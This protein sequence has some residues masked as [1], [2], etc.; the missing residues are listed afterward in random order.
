MTRTHADHPVACEN[1]QTPLQGD[2][3]YRCGQS[4]HNPLRHTGHALEEVFESF[5]HLDGR[6]FRTLRDLLSPGRAA[7][8][9]L[10]G[11]R[12]RYIPPLRMFV[13]LSLLTF[14][15]GKL[16]V[17]A[18]ST[19]P[20]NAQ[21]TFG[22]MQ[23]IEQV[24]RERDRLLAELDK[25]REDARSGTA[26]PGVDPA[27]IAAQVRIRGEANNRITELRKARGGEA[28]AGSAESHATDPVA[29]RGQ[30]FST[31][32]QVWDPETSAPKIDGA[33]GFIN[34]W[35]KDKTR[36]GHENLQRMQN[37]PAMLVK[38]IMT[39]IPT[40]LFVLVPV[41]ALLLKLAYVFKRRGYL[42]HLVIALYSHCYI[43]MVLAL[44]FATAGLGSL[45][46]V[47]APWV[48]TLSTLVIIG[49]SLWIP[50]YLL[51]MQK[52]VYQQ[53]WPMTLVKYLIVGYIYCVLLM[54]VVSLVMINTL[55]SHF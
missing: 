7:I 30:L 36:V 1:C 52:R 25:A 20:G 44:I 47:H 32:S 41:F 16:G 3:C 49:L 46:A 22:N 21:N 14:F 34:Q 29:T 27:L 15:I 9:Y 18:D 43:L 6:V 26:V 53:G 37:D 5:W 54:L 51:L 24:E 17:H 28:A 42:E 10:A 8:N 38:W 45:L 11:H 33:P 55:G 23:T 35:L 31:D 48:S 12:V 4:A 2:Y 40:A 50:V 39:S 19:L 13:I